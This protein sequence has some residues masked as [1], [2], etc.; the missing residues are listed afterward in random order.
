MMPAAKSAAI[1]MLATMPMIIRSIVGG[2]SSAAAPAAPIS[3]V[4]KGVG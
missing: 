4:L 2:M 1:D 3:A